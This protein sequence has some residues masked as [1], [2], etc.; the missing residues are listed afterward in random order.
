LQNARRDGSGAKLVPWRQRRGQVHRRAYAFDAVGNRTSATDPLGHTTTYAFD[1]QNRLTAVTDGLNH[2]TTYGYDFAGRQTSITDPVNNVWNY[3]YDSANR[4]T[5][6]T[7]PLNHTTTYAYDTTDFDSDVQSL[8]AIMAECGR[9][10]ISFQTRVAHLNGSQEGG[11]SASNAIDD[12]L[13]LGFLGLPLVPRILDDK[14]DNSA[15]DGA[16][17]LLRA[18]QPESWAV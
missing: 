6:V 8:G 11:A 17:R 2:T 16:P 9:T 14:L 3:G 15:A 10:V 5:A 12:Y 4:L 7:D 18:A 13:H 1:P